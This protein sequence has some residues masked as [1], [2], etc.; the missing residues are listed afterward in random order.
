MPTVSTMTRAGRGLRESADGLF[1]TVAVTIRGLGGPPEQWEY[2]ALSAA[3][4][5]RYGDGHPFI[6]NLYVQSIDEVAVVAAGD[7][8]VRI[9]LTYGPPTAQSIPASQSA[10]L[11]LEI[12]AQL[13]TGKTQFDVDGNQIVLSYT[14]TSG[15]RAGHTVQQ[16]GEVDLDYVLGTAKGARREQLTALQALEKSMAYAGTVNDFPWLGYPARTWRCMPILYSDP[17]DKGTLLARYEFVYKPQTWDV[18]AVYVDPDSGRPPT[19]LV[20]NIG[21]KTVQVLP[22]SDFNSLNAVF[23]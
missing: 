13:S 9:T 6:P 12:G 3:G 15:T 22:T 19:D 18:T 23:L 17:D 5:P 1:H 14:Y 10:P 8:A 2:A 16:A 7:A 11:Q 4:V 21:Y 20:K